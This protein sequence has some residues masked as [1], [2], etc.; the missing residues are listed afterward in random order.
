MKGRRSKDVEANVKTQS[1]VNDTVSEMRIQHK[2]LQIQLDTIEES[3]LRIQLNSHGFTSISRVILR[4]QNSES[5][6]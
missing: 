4:L 2:R 5:I 1:T 3:L 6:G